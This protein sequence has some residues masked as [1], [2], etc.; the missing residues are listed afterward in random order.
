MHMTKTKW[1][2]SLVAALALALGSTSTVQAAPTSLG[3]YA[4]N[5]GDA[6]GVK[7]CDELILEVTE[8][9]GI[10]KL[11]GFDDFGPCGQPQRK[12]PVY[13]TAIVLPDG[14][15]RVAFTMHTF[16]PELETP[17]NGVTQFAGDLN[18]TTLSGTIRGTGGPFVG[19]LNF[20][21][22]RT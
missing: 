4:W 19:T 5:F 15:I 20:I 8:A 21:G 14:K 12:L 10:Y 2:I 7:F 3:K 17:A 22:Q 11:T 9:S 1:V 16:F 18:P 13:G 6:N